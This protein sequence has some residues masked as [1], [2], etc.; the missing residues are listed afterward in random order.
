MRQ[1]CSSGG[2][3]RWRRGRWE[4]GV[5][6]GGGGVDNY[7]MVLVMPILNVDKDLCLYL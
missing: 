6:D 7:I 2:G 5:S 4:G 1:C 3:G